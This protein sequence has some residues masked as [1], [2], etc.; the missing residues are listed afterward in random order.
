MLREGD[1]TQ[2]EEGNRYCL[3]I[4]REV[5]G[6]CSKRGCDLVGFVK[7]I[8]KPY[9]RPDNSVSLAQAWK[10]LEGFGFHSKGDANTYQ[11]EE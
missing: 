5:W 7:R 9:G 3:K 10:S 4:S 11:P 1:L 8:Q 6:T 2:L